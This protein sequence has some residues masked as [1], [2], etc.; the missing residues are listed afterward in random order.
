MRQQ[1]QVIGCGNNLA[2]AAL[3]RW[4]AAAPRLRRKP[5]RWTTRT[6]ARDT[7]RVWDWGASD[8][9]EAAHERCWDN[10]LCVSPRG[11][12]SPSEKVCQRLAK[13]ARGSEFRASLT[14]TMVLTQTKPSVILMLYSHRQHHLHCAQR[15]LVHM[16]VKGLA[17]RMRKKP[18]PS[19]KNAPEAARRLRA[20]AAAAS[21]LVP[22]QCWAPTYLQAKLPHVT[23]RRKAQCPARS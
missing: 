22:M 2:A 15:H 12:Q 21:W 1:E 18:S 23:M 16:I 7:M 13:P 10:K 9:P 20:R 11:A 5:T 3:V 17:C 6:D 19:S 8:A 14:A 4:T